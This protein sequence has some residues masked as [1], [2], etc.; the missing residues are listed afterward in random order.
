MVKQISETFILSILILT[1]IGCR[2][3]KNNKEEDIEFENFIK[4]K[5]RNK[6]TVGDFEK[7][8]EYKKEQKRLSLSH[9]PYLKVN[10]VYVYQGPNKITFCIYSDD[11]NL[12][13]VRASRTDGAFL[14]EPKD[15]IIK[16][17]QPLTLEF[18][19]NF[20]LKGTVIKISRNERA[21]SGKE[22]NECDVGYLKNDT[23]TFTENYDTK[24]Y[25][26]KKKWLAKTYKTNFKEV[27]QP[28]LIV[29]RHEGDKTHNPYFLIEGLFNAEKNLEEDKML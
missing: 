16:L 21:L 2:T 29:T 23:I 26:Y 24:K 27:Y 19:G 7:F 4:P 18:L 11:E 20:E 9:D 3:S 15:G 6:A 8:L 5:D 17:K 12:Y 25:E 13:L 28:D 1:L 22:W 10:T 14:T